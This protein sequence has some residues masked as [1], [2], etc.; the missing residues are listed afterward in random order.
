MAASV[1][2][3]DS[4][5]SVGPVCPWS[6][7]PSGLVQ[8]NNGSGG[9]PAASPSIARITDRSTSGIHGYKYVKGD[10]GELG[11]CDPRNG[12][13]PWMMLTMGSTMELVKLSM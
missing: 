2:S 12:I 11:E 5:D 10:F 4:A 9:L 13:E 1:G 3:A 8:R 7:V 6:R